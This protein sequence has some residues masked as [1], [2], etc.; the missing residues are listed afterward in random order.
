MSGIIINPYIYAAT[1][2]TKLVLEVDIDITDASGDR[3]FTLVTRGSTANGLD[4]SVD[5]GDGN[6]DNNITTGTGITHTYASDGTYLIKIDGRAG[7]YFTDGA[8]ATT[9]PKIT[10]LKNWGTDEFSFMQIYGA[11]Q[12]CENMLYEATDYPDLSTIVAELRGDSMLRNCDSITSLDL[13]NWQDI[14]NLTKLLSL[15]R[16]NIN[17]TSINLTGWDTSNITAIS[18]MFYNVGSSGAGC[19]IIAPNLDFSSVGSSLFQSI[20]DG[21]PGAKIS[22]LNVTNWTMPS[23]ATSY[24]RLFR[25]IFDLTSIDVSTWNSFKPSSCWEMFTNS[26]AL[27]TINISG[28]DTSASTTFRSM[29]H[30][31]TALTEIEGLDELDSTAATGVNGVY[32]MFNGCDNL[33]FANYNLSNDFGTNLSNCTSM[34]SMFQDVGKTTPTVPPNIANFDTSA[35]TSF[36]T[37]FHDAKFTTTLD[38]SILDMSAATTLYRF[39][40]NQDGITSIDA[41]S[42]G[43]TNALT[44]FQDFCQSAEITDIEFGSGSD[45]SGVTTFKNC[46]LNCGD[47]TSIDFPTNADFSS[48]T[49]M[50]NFMSSSNTNMSVAE[51]DNFLKRF[52]A[53]NSNSGVTL[54]FGLCDYTFGEVDSGTTDGTTANKLVDSSQNFVTTVGIGDI[55]IKDTETTTDSGWAK[56]TAVDSNSVLSVDDDI[57][58]SGDDY[59]I[60]DS[61]VVKA[62][63]EILVLGNTIIDGDG[64]N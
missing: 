62:K 42:W 21:N 63:Y 54:G 13:S 38:L 1:G 64:I 32:R 31:C 4:Y 41:S 10:S 27:T 9:R 36:S 48:V 14:D 60:G 43:F 25:E 17:L 28:I 37:M 30:G 35:V 20:F 58:T 26:E 29:F 49:N 11:F 18:S 8:A 50:T 34:D 40:R 44:T 53:T 33:S 55:I 5:W 12:G 2:E 22:T 19:E 59:R 16:D 3:D 6:S 52:D 47:L 24:Y 39:M 46:F 61:D 57:F 45:F 56:V 7:I 15:F 23:S 51:Y